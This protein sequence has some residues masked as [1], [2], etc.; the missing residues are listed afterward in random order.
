[1]AEDKVKHALFNLEDQIYFVTEK[2]KTDA[3][4]ALLV[5]N[6]LF[7]GLLEFY[8]DF[9]QIWKPAPKEIL[10]VLRKIAPGFAQQADALLGAESLEEKVR[11]FEAMSR[12]FTM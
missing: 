8:F 1:M 10:Q 2:A 6:N 5:F 9:H 11:I 4:T 3:P 12:T 7:S